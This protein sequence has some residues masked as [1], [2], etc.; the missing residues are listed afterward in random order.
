MDKEDDAR[1]VSTLLYCLGDDA[2]DVLA[3]TNISADDR[4]KFDKV[5]EKFDAHFQVRKNVIY[6]RAHFNKRSQQDGE[7]AEEYVTALYGLIETCEF[8]DLKEELLRD[9]IVVGIRS[10]AV[11]EKLQ[12]DAKLTLETAKKEVRQREAIR[13]QSHKLQVA[14]SNHGSM[15]EVRRPRPQRSRGGASNYMQSTKTERRSRP[16]VHAMWQS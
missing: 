7:T 14:D 12:M 3:S 5:V 15:G 13:E 4:K 1:K 8:G 9:R 2:H 6:E 10:Q 16:Q 11:S